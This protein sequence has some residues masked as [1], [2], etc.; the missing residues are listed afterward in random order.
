[1]PQTCLAASETCLTSQPLSPKGPESYPPHPQLSQ[2]PLVSPL[3]F[4]STLVYHIN[5][6]NHSTSLVSC[7]TSLIPQIDNI[8]S[9]MY[10]Q[11]L[12]PCHHHSQ[13]KPSLLSCILTSLSH[14]STLWSQTS[15]A[16]APS[17]KPLRSSKFKLN[18]TTQM[19]NTRPLLN[20]IYIQILNNFKQFWNDAST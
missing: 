13:L 14:K 10:G 3:A 7:F 6:C 20:Y 5:L 19:S 1:M 17:Q 12:E 16:A 9:S 4:S 8:S 15:F 11:T 18:S 2:Y